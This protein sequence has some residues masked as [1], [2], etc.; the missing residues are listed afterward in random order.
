MF[1]KLFKGKGKDKERPPDP[2]ESKGQSETLFELIADPDA[3][4]ALSPMDLNLAV[5][6][7]IGLYGTG[8]H[9]QLIQSILPLYDYYQLVVPV[10]VRRISYGV[11]SKQAAAGLVD[12][13]AFLPYLFCEQ[14]TGI[15]SMASA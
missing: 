7:A 15:V 12:S 1:Q 5:V 11:V 2:A 9:P 8:R 14:E 4:Q 10:E 3:Y 6:E 13:I